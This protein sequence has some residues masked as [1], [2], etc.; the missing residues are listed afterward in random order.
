MLD[1]IKNIDEIFKINKYL[2]IIPRIQNGEFH[3]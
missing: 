1:K 2:C 3:L